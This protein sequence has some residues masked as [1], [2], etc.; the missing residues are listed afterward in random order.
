MKQR[1]ICTVDVPLDC[2][3]ED[4]TPLRS[5]WMVERHRQAFI[6]ITLVDTAACQYRSVED[7]HGRRLCH[8]SGE[9]KDVS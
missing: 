8:A 1:M 3:E 5:V 4:D 6:C 7:D 2:A 9:V